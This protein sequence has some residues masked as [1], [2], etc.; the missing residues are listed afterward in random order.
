MP[1]PLDKKI[2]KEASKKVN[3]LEQCQ[4]AISYLLEEIED[5]NVKLDKVMSRMGL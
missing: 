1:K 5:M 2:K 3:A 4:K